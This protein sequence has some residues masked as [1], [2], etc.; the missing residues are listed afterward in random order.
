MYENKVIISLE[1]YLEFYNLLKKKENQLN[2]LCSL[3]LNSTKLND[4]KDKLI[5]DGYNMK[6]GRTLDL[7][8]EI[9]PE[10]FKIRLENLQK[11]E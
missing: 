3:I 11:G 2:Q 5:I 9:M 6:Y 7:I 10:E 4:V 1:N 8:K